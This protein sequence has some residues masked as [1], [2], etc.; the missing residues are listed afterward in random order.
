MFSQLSEIY[1]PVFTVHFGSE[2]VVILH[3]YEAVK[4]ALIDH[5][6]KFAAR[7]HMPIGDKFNNGLGTFSAL[8]LL[9]GTFSF[10]RAGG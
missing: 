6:D 8:E 7:G 9:V 3:G 10:W 2:R 5:A 1:G 4:E